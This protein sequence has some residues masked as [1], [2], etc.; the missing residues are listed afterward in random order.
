[1]PKEHLREVKVVAS[2]EEIRE[3][4][5]VLFIVTDLVV[6]FDAFNYVHI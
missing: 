6:I 1:M 2:E 5:G 4:R 3:G